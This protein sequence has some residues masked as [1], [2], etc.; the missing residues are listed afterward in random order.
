MDGSVAICSSVDDCDLLPKPHADTVAPSPLTSAA[1]SMAVC[2]SVLPGAAS[3]V[4]SPFEMNSTSLVASARPPSAKSGRA[5]SNGLGDG[6]G[7]LGDGGGGLGG[8]I[9]G[10][11]GDSGGWRG[12]GIGGGLGGDGWLGGGD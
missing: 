1:A 4:W 8:G 10:G 11:E 7:G 3:T 5:V 6:G 12:G 2:N 9:G